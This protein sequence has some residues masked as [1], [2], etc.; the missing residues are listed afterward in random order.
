MPQAPAPT[1]EP[2]TPLTKPGTL[3]HH[4]NDMCA[5]FAADVTLGGANAELA[6]CGQWLPMDGDPDMP[7]GEL[8]L[9]NSSGP[10]RLGYGAWRDLLLGVQFRNGRGVLISAGGMTVKN[11]AGYD[12]T[13]FFVGSGGATG[14]GCF[15]T[16]VTLTTRTDRL[17]DG[18]L[19]AD[20][21]RW[22]DGFVHRLIQSELRPQWMIAQ[23]TGLT[24]GYLGRERQLAFWGSALRDGVVGRAIDRIRG[25]GLERADELRRQRWL[26]PPLGNVR[27]S[28]PPA[29][30]IDALRTARV[31]HWSLNP[32]HGLAV[33]QADDPHAVADELAKAGGRS[34][35][36]EDGRPVW[37]DVD[38]GTRVLLD[39]LKTAF[40]PDGLL[41]G[42][43]LTDA[44]NEVSRRV[45][46]A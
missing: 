35:I 32:V 11:V 33:V 28:L 13:K 46:R 18:G 12:L 24:L 10:M 26:A 14:T 4:A 9:M 17:P 30:A 19:L 23:P 2:R 44:P 25:V 21:E 43:P 38:A 15:G 29:S 22:D 6:R 20:L 41:P 45:E 1:R 16:P 27:T 40:D 3:I 8:L 39:R 5:T 7:L 31:E 42:L 34:T 36:F 37:W